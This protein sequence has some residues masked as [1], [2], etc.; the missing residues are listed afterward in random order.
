MPHS[1]DKEAVSFWYLKV[2]AVVRMI[3]KCAINGYQAIS[4][5][6]FTN[7]MR[8]FGGSG[9]NCITFGFFRERKL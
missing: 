1:V 4:D 9:G 5:H 7:Q 8:L 3:T 2:Q 6:R